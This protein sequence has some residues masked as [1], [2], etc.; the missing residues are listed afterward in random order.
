MAQIWLQGFRPPKIQSPQHI[1]PDVV[2]FR[3]K[4][5]V[6]FEAVDH[7]RHLPQSRDKTQKSPLETNQGHPAAKDRG[8]L[9]FSLKSQQR[10]LT[11]FKAHWIFTG[12]AMAPTHEKT[13][14]MSTLREA[15]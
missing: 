10:S 1:R 13:D 12:A 3:G 5:S 9:M 7:S 6:T 2:P 14:P 4:H 15:K 11:G 8:V